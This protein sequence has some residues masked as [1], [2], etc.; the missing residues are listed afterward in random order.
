MNPTRAEGPLSG[1]LVV[2]IEQAVAAP[3]C[4]LRLADAGARVIKIEREGGET[5]R[6]YD[7][8]VHGT[9]AYFAW[10]NRGKESAVLDLKAPA[11]LAVL[12]A[13]LDRADV[14][15]QNLIPGAMARMGLGPGVIAARFP[16]LIAVSINGYG[17]DTPYAAM[18][19]YDLLVQAESGICAVTGT[20][21]T[22]SKIGV[23]AADIATGMNAHAAILEALI[24][25]TR[26]GQGKQIEIAMFDGMADWM[27][28][29]LLHHEHGGRTT[30]RHG[31]SHASIYPYRPFAC[32]DGTVII[33][34]QTDAEW[35]RLCDRVLDRPDL[36]QRP[37]F[38]S[39]AQRVANR[40][41]LDRELEPVFATLALAEAIARL[42]AAGVAWGRYNDVPALAAHPALRRVAVALPSGDRVAIPRPAGRDAD[43]RPGPVPGLGAQTEAIRAEFAPLAK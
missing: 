17:Q 35:R 1:L 29:P 10:L 41:A 34:V 16:R 28:V 8:A 12:F 39:N 31:L 2:A 22:P 4:T 20:P 32:A 42:Q 5:A 11:D 43:F 13:M 6:H 7:E 18:R 26:T 38:A 30:G 15:V 24:T 27:T 23:S 33:A 3:L 25:R 40:T 36:A 9:S 19:A 21:D 37:D 14:L